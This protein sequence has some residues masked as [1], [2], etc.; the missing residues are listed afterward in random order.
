MATLAITFTARRYHATSWGLHVNEGGLDWPPAPWRLLRALLAVGFA[1]RG[2]SGVPDPAR[3]LITRLA[4]APPSFLLPDGGIAHTRHY[5][6]C[7]EGAA[8]RTTKVL[9]TFLRLTDDTPLLVTWPV[10]LTGDEAAICADLAAGLAYLGRAESW[11]QA[12]L[13]DEVPPDGRWARPCADGQAVPPDW[14]QVNL[15]APSSAD[16]YAAFRQ[17]RLAAIPDAASDARADARRAAAYPADLIACL[18]A[19]TDTLRAQ[20]WS[21]PPGSRKMLYLRPA[22]AMRPA[23]GMPRQPR[24]ASGPVEAMLLALSTG[25][26]QVRPL[27]HHGLPQ[28]ELLHATA[29]SMLG[30]QAASCPALTGRDPS[31]GAPLHGHRHARLL[32]LD[33]DGD[34]RIDHVLLHA[35]D[36][37][38][39]LAQRAIARITRTW[40]DGLPDVTVS[41]AGQ[42]DLA[43]FA[44][45]LRDDAGRPL[46]EFGPAVTWT[47]STPFIAPRFRKP[48]G[49][50]SLIGQVEEECAVQGLP[51]PAVTVLP[52]TE[53]MR[54]GFLHHVRQRRPGH[55]QP[56]DT[57]PWA[58]H[59]TFP[60][61]VHGP[62]ALGYGSHYGLGILVAE[63][64]PPPS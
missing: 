50:N 22:E 26:G 63:V 42:G 21:Q 15:L 58:L 13:V 52:R 31:T 39:A 32:P 60:A 46:P 2:W 18:L 62:I 10:V 57:A 8:T 64:D 3:A 33:L 34:G 37:F 30:N 43:L 53:M 45:L 11:C 20:G 17:D 47:S 4:A 40:G 54:R 48:G 44:R 16:D 29:V 6:P 7:S 27:R 35:A 9:D 51:T 25:T 19:D 56:P 12:A 55:A 24:P 1:K 59:L 49:R 41:L 28:M 14:E 61:P 23:V 5:L 36:G 38:D